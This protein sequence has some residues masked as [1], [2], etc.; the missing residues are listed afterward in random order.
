MQQTHANVAI[1]P[2]ACLNLL[3]DCQCLLTACMESRA[4]KL[5]SIDQS[6]YHTVLVQPFLEKPDW[7][8]TYPICVGSGFD[9]CLYHH[10]C[11]AAVPGSPDCAASLPSPAHHCCTVCSAGKLF[12]FGTQTPS[13]TPGKVLDFGTHPPL[14]PLPNLPSKITFQTYSQAPQFASQNNI[15]THFPHYS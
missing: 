5:F 13:H 14:T 6:T 11:A 12:D 4:S 2:P 1:W 9:I 3:A 7:S 8:C 10:C 15:S